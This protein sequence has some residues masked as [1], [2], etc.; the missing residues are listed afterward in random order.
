MVFAVFEKK[1]QQF[2]DF[3]LKV[4]SLARSVPKPLQVP[5]LSRSMAKPLK[6]PSLARSVPKLLL[7]ERT[8]RVSPNPRSKA[9]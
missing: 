6:V 2:L 7:I 9:V 8:K 3:F 1:K 5:S 4:P